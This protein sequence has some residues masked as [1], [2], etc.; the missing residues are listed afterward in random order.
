MKKY[1]Y[2][3][4]EKAFFRSSMECY[5]KFFYSHGCKLMNLLVTNI[6]EE[7]SSPPFA[8]ACDNIRRIFQ[9]ENTGGQSIVQLEAA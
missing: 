3:D 4:G 7:K 9:F 6:F 8:K 2:Y 1:T 5:W